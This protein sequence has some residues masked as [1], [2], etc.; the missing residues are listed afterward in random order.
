[1]NTIFRLIGRALLVPISWI[2]ISRL[3]GRIMRLRRPRW[4]ALWMIRRFRKSYRIDMAEFQGQTDDYLSLSEFFLRPFDPCKRPLP[5]DPGCLL[6]PADGRL[7]EL[8]LVSEDRATQVKGWTYPLSLMLG[9]AL[10]F[11]RGWHV[12]MIYLSPSDYHR[13]H[14]PLSGRISGS[15]HGG[16]RL[17]P[18]NDFSATRVRRLYVRNERV[19]TRFEFRGAHLYM[20]AVGAT[21]VGNIG[22]KHLPGG[23]PVLDKW[24]RL[25]LAAEQMAE[26]GHFAMGSTIILAVPA[27]LVE[28]VLAQ[29]GDTIRVG[30]PLFKFKI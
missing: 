16:T 10:D 30:Q 20:V 1:M 14:Y 4:L 13:F 9:E 19:V 7:S 2:P 25:D 18:V 17:F 23:L 26:M 28:A 5:G 21:F 22:M 12:A 27:A 29:K 3:Y 8:E 11:S 24:Q 6:S 15:F